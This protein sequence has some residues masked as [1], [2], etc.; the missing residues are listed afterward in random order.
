MFWLPPLSSSGQLQSI[1]KT[2][3]RLHL[4]EMRSHFLYSTVFM[5]AQ[6]GSRSFLK[7]LLVEENIRIA[8][9][10][11]LFNVLILVDVFGLTSS[12]SFKIILPVVC[13]TVKKE[14]KKEHTKFYIISVLLCRYYIKFVVF[15]GHLFVSFFLYSTTHNRVYSFK[16]E[17]LVNTS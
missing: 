13:H 2:K 12:N 6:F 16:K 11:I 9:K 10:Y 1:F 8:I 3:C 4:L 14:R 15:K 17:F 5:F 7:S